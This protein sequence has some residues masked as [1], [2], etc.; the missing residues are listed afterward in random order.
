MVQPKDQSQFHNASNVDTERLPN[1]GDR[2]VPEPGRQTQEKDWGPDLVQPH[3]KVLYLFAGAQRKNDVGKYVRRKAK[4]KRWRL[5]FREVD[6][7]RNGS[8]DDLLDETVWQPL[9][10]S[11]RRG[12]WNALLATPPCC[13]FSRAK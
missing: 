1:E 8:T 7:V 6:L 11:L 12:E 5:T 9:Q 4:Q 2:V 13:E 10:N 3:L